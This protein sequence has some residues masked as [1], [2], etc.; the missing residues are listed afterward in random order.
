M[1]ILSNPE[2]GRLDLTDIE[3][4]II[5]C[6]PLKAESKLNLIEYRNRKMMQYATKTSHN[7]T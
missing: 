3:F 2:W 1:E 6:N 5:K 4:R 7:A